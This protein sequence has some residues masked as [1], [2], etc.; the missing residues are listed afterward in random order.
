MT[1]RLEHAQENRIIKLG[2]NESQATAMHNINNI[3]F[4]KE[5]RWY[6]KTQKTKNSDLIK[7]VIPISL[8]TV[9]IF[10]PFLYRD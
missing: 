9:C 2:P 6:E 4:E 1:I 8:S 3:S 10:Q 7:H 5:K